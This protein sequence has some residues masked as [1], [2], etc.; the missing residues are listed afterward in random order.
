MAIMIPSEFIEFDPKSREEF[1]YNKFSELPNEYYVFHSLNTLEVKNI[2][3]R[4][5]R[6]GEIDF[7]LLHQVKGLIVIEAK[8]GEFKIINSQWYYQNGLPM[9]HGGPYNQAKN[10][11]YKLQNIIEREDK[12]NILKGKLNILHGV[13]FPSVN[14]GILKNIK[15]PLEAH[16]AITICNDDLDNLVSSLDRI[17]EQSFETK[18]LNEI[19]FKSLLDIL[20]P[21]Y[22]IFQIK[23][24]EVKIKENKFIRLLNEQYAILDYLEFQNFATISGVAGTGK[25]LIALEKARRLSID[26]KVLF[27]CY[28]KHLRDYLE[29][30][31]KYDNIDYFT[32]DQYAYKYRKKVSNKYIGLSQYLETCYLNE[33][34][35]DYQHLIIDE[36]Q[37]FGSTDLE[38]AEVLKYFYYNV[39][40]KFNGSMYIFYDK[41]QLV[42]G[43]VVPK[44]IQDSDCKLTLYKNCRN[45]FNIAKTALKPIEVTPKVFKGTYEGVVPSLYMSDE[46]SN[47][48]EQVKKIVID[49]INKGYQNITVLSLKGSDKSFMIEVNEFE[50]I[51]IEG[52]YFQWTTSRKFKGLESDVIILV[53][54]DK[55][56]FIDNKLLFYVGASRAKYELAIF[57]N[58]SKNDGNEVLEQLEMNNSSKIHPKFKLAAYLNA[59]VKS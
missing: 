12:T 39:V 16:P 2:N 37:D 47:L 44:I 6:D 1:I 30:N 34:T 4:F 5:S 9:K 41:M 49:Y 42:Q 26:K 20:L 54:I 48:M 10:N 21:S 50:K 51:P 24:V 32:I 56:T 33:K 36:G 31:Y 58:M 18:A 52:S 35:F 43:D 38:T 29:A 55:R 3:S 57:V 59:S 53:D 14:S 17:Y 23:N 7:L 28:N 27:L 11:K 25:T 13:C 22:N 15:L 19:E 8:A 45:T 46:N 40:D